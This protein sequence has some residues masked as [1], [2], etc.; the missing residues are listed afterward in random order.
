MIVS[1]ML[2]VIK[3]TCRGSLSASIPDGICEMMPPMIE[4][5]RNSAIWEIDRPTA[6]AN[7]G[8]IDPKVA[9]DKPASA[10]PRE[11]NGETRNATKG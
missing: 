10:T 9:V 1:M 7:R 3:M 5:T 2:N 6:L 8:L 11:A 4:T